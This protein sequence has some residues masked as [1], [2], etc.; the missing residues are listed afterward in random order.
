M[1]IYAH[2][3]HTRMW[4][5][6]CK[7]VMAFPRWCSGVVGWY[8]CIYHTY[9]IYNYILMTQLNDPHSHI[10]HPV[11]VN[12]S[13]Y[14]VSPYD[15]GSSWQRF[16]TSQ[17]HG[18][19][20]GGL[21]NIKTICSAEWLR[22][23]IATFVLLLWYRQSGGRPNKDMCTRNILTGTNG[24]KSQISTVS[25]VLCPQFFL[26]TSVS[27]LA[28]TSRKTNGLVDTGPQS[29]GSNDME[30]RTSSKQKP[31]HFNKNPSHINPPPL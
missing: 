9:G 13:S 29:Y 8:S 21:Y 19:G 20:G 1:Q 7:C 2:V 15:K 28:Y 26:R 31:S 16:L 10:S 23:S 3:A 12:E 27:R 24:I 17:R 25:T 22:H 4:S 14:I 18:W 6:D 30:S 5:V 11:T